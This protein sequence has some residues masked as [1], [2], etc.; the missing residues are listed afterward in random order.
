MKFIHYTPNIIPP[1][2]P[3]WNRA[4][5]STN[6]ADPF[7]NCEA[8]QLSFQDAFSPNRKL[9]YAEYSGSVCVFA[10]FA[11]SPNRIFLTPV[12]SHWFFGSPLLG[13]DAVDILHN[14]FGFLEKNYGRTFPLFALGGVRPQGRLA[15]RLFKAFG[16]TFT[17]Y[18]HA[19]GEQGCAS[20]NG[21][22]EGFL[23][24]RSANHRAKVRK[25]ARRVAEAGV[26]FERVQPASS[27]EASAA[28][29]RIIAIER[30]SWKG[31]DQCGMTESPS[32]EFYD[33][34]LQRLSATRSARIIFAR[35][36]DNDIGFI[37]GS[38]AGK[39][40]RG[41]QFSYDN[42]WRHAGLGNVLQLE[43]VRWLCEQGAKRYDMGPVTG[44]KMDYKRHWTEKHIPVETWILE[45]N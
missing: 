9:L 26:C 25:Q 23:G 21:G 44:P 8:W 16:K 12:E 28:Y 11:F 43:K 31:I 18:L 13:P 20:L 42:T 19:T 37:F 4:A 22:V 24:R 14:S 5:T 29:Q 35:H 27:K 17:F 32:K 38:M 6:Q 3:A 15:R 10:E 33:I 1:Q 40:Y 41:Q 36:E 2:F 34:M 7:C 30:Q 45:R 39:I